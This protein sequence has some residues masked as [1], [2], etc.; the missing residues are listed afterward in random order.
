MR[1]PITRCGIADG[2]L[3][4]TDSGLIG[5]EKPH[6]AIF[7]AALKSLGARAEESLYVGDVY[8]VDYQGATGAGMQAVLFDLPG[9]Y[10]DKGLPRVESLEELV[11]MVG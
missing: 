9:A 4:I 10:R 3:S 7:E 2:F 1:P 5:H 11:S 8:S 6:P